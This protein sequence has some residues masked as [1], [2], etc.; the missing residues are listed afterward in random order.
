[1]FS[2]A[3]IKTSVI[4]LAAVCLTSLPAAA[5]SV[6]DFE[7]MPSAEQSKY[8]ADFVEKMTDDIGKTNPKLE[9][10]IRDYFVKKQPG[11][12]VSDGVE[13]VLVELTALDRTAKTGKA[14]LSKIQ[15][16]SIVVYVVKQKFPPPS[17]EQK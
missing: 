2:A 5:K 13:K 1:M 3:R 6:K 10:D 8:V 7:A 11:K 16:E 17:P 15:I 14:D 9:Q 12:P 4:I